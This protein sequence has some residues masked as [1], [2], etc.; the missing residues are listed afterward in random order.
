MRGKTNKQEITITAQAY[1]HALRIIRD[2]YPDMA[3]ELQQ[4]RAYELAAKICRK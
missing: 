1:A 3:E 4:R 2:A